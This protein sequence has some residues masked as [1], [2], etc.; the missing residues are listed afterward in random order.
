MRDVC[1][2]VLRAGG[3]DFVSFGICVEKED[4]LVV[5]GLIIY[6]F[7]EGGEFSVFSSDVEVVLEGVTLY[8]Q[9]G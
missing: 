8:W 3:E 5:Y 9:G 7:S 4:V 1:F 2:V 6:G